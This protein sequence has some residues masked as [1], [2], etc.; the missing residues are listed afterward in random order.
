MIDFQSIGAGSIPAIRSINN[1]AVG[2]L[3]K[4]S[5]FESEDSNCHCWFDPSLRSQTKKN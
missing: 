5:D 2:K 4:P 1:S 3:V